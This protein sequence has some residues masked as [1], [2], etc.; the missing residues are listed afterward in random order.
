MSAEEFYNENHI[1]RENKLINGE[2]F[3]SL[4]EHIRLSEAY[5]E[6]KV[7]ADDIYTVLL[8]YGIDEPKASAIDESIKSKLKE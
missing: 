6:S 4:K 5:H 8:Y 2:E 3:I 7:D 1:A